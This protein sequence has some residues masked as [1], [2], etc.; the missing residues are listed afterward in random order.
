[1]PVCSYLVAPTEGHRE[2]VASAL[3]RLPGCDVVPAE[4]RDLL[5]LVTDTADLAAEA[6]LRS[7]IEAIPGVRGLVMAFGEI[8]PES[9]EPD[10]L[11]HSKKKKRRGALPVVDASAPTAPPTPSDLP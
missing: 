7:S 8:D 3:A 1:M 6:E 2:D 11:A 9:T 10:P 4:N 5:L